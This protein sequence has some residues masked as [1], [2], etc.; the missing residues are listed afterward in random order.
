MRFYRSLRSLQNDSGGIY[1]VRSGMTVRIVHFYAD[2]TLQKIRKLD[3]IASV[4]PSGMTGK[5]VFIIDGA[6]YIFLSF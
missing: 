6:F 2:K 5:E 3:D 1:F 4:S